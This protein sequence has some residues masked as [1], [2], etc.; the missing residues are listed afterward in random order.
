MF[1]TIG[2][3]A[4]EFDHLMEVDMEAHHHEELGPSQAIGKMADA[5]HAGLG[6]V[7]A[8]LGVVITMGKISEPPE[9]LGHSTRP[10]SAPSWACSP[11]YGF[12]GPISQ[13]LEHRANEANV[14]LAVIRTT[15]VSFISNPCPRSPWKPAD[16]PF[17]ARTVPPSRNSRKS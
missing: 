1:I 4:H 11:C 13:N 3:E 7:A 15:L 17:R 8:V 14:Y 5:L 16:G 2:M 12:V 10:W 6:I 9:V